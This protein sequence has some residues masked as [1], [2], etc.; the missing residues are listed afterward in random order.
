MNSIKLFL[1]FGASILLCNTIDVILAKNWA[2]ILVGLNYYTYTYGFEAM[3]YKHYNDMVRNGV[4]P[5]NIIVISPDTAAYHPNNPMPGLVA[6]AYDKGEFS[7]ETPV[8]QYENVVVDYKGYD[9]TMDQFF[10][11]LTGNF[12]VNLT[13]IGSGRVLKT[14]PTDT[15]F[16]YI[17]T[18]GYEGIYL[19]NNRHLLWTDKMIP[20]LEEMSEMKKFKKMFIYMHASYSGAMFDNYMDTDKKILVYSM[21]GRYNEFTMCHMNKHLM[22]YTSSCQAFE[23]LSYLDKAIAK[24]GAKETVLDLYSGSGLTSYDM[25]VVHNLYGDFS[26]ARMPIKEFYGPKMKNSQ[27]VTPTEISK[28]KK[29]AEKQHKTGKSI[30]KMLI[31]EETSAQERERV[32]NS[33]NKVISESIKNTKIPRN[34]VNERVEFLPLK[35]FDCYRNALETMRSKCLTEK[36]QFLYLKHA[37]QLAK[38]C[39]LNV[40][41][42]KI[43]SAIES[44]C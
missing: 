38:L 31:N 26:L 30:T 14:G 24:N 16:L 6:Y 8:N 34:I 42:D 1:L 33:M 36:S 39:S 19:L 23:H 3:A 28:L 5:E 40:S 9:M 21:G 20:V 15:I 17:H 25:E 22:A 11:I 7:A 43:V 18:I 41:K 10:Q 32:D 44:A 35:K 2:V 37:P 13:D 27:P 29:E 12:T 4:D